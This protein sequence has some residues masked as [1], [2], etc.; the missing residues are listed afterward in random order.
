MGLPSDEQG[1][2]RVDAD[3]AVNTV[4]NPCGDTSTTTT[5]YDELDGSTDTDCWLREWEYAK[6]CQAVVDLS[7]PSNAD[8]DLYVNEGSGTCPTHSNYDYRGFSI[9][10]QETIVI[11]DPDT[12]APLFVMVDSWSGSGSY[13]LSITEKGT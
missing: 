13:T 5:L 11:D 8:F 12:S 2:G 6:P 1:S 7:G 3:N 4:P 10:S 9:D